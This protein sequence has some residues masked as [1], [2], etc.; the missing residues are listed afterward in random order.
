MHS[1][2]AEV[3]FKPSLPVPEK[4]VVGENE[5][6]TNKVGAWEDISVGD[7]TGETVGFFD[8]TLVGNFVG[9]KEGLWETK[10]VGNRVGFLDGDKVEGNN[11]GLVL[12]G[13]KVGALK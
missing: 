10:L 6:G 3:A 4:F 5:G 2:E 8:G 13:F 11:V 12:V 9:L 1:T 7:E